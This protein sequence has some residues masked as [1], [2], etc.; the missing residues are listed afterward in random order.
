MKN[1]TTSEAAINGKVQDTENTVL[2]DSLGQGMHAEK[3]HDIDADNKP[4]IEGDSRNPTPQNNEPV[5]YSD[6]NTVIE[7]AETREGVGIGQIRLIGS[8]VF[9]M[10]TQ[11]EITRVI[12]ALESL[13]IAQGE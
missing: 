4:P 10:K 6:G 3:V 9:I 7:I 12:E 11:G 1:K 5:M 2:P 8:R 13:R